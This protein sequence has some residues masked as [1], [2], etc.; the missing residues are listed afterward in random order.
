MKTAFIFFSSLGLFFYFFKNFFF[1]NVDGADNVGVVVTD[2]AY[3]VD[4]L[5]SFCFFY[6]YSFGKVDGADN[7]GVVVTD[8]AYTVD[9]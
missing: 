5:F 7:V 1:Q 8:V 2:V 9:I 3:T 6:F 4:F